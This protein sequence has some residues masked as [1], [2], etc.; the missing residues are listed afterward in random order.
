M[1]FFLCRDFTI[2]QASLLLA[3]CGF[4]LVS[5]FCHVSGKTRW[6]LCFLVAGSFCLFLFSSLLDPFLNL[7]DERFHA[8][9]A[10]NLMTH[11][12][13]PMLYADPVV[14]IP[15]DRWDR[16]YI[17]LNKQPFF[18]WPAAFFFHIFGV[19]EFALR[20]P[21]ALAGSILVLLAVRTGRLLVSDKTGYY[22][23]FLFATAFYMM[24]IISG[25]Q[26]LEHND[27]AFL[28]WVSASIWA[29]V[30]YVRS[31]K[32]RWMIF[33]AV[34][35]GVAI[36]VKWLVGLLV[37]LGW[38]VYIAF[39]RDRRKQEMVRLLLALSITF[40]VAVPWYGYILFNYPVEAAM[41][42][43]LYTAHLTMPLDGH[44]GN[45]WFHITNLPLLYGTL[46]TYLLIPAL[47]VLYQ[48][49]TP[50]PVTISLI[51]MLIATYLFF[52]IAQTKMPSLPWVASLPVYISIGTLMDAV[53]AWFHRI[54]AP[55][56]VLFVSTFL[57]LAVIGYFNLGIPELAYKHT[58]DVKRNR[59]LGNLSH[60]KQIFLDLPEQLPD[61]SVV[62]NVK[63][64]H[65]IECMFYS[66]FTSYPFI[67]STS[68]INDLHHQG[69]PV[70]I[71][72]SSRDTLPES[73]WNNQG[74]FIIH[75]TLQGWD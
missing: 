58:K 27:M 75:K 49:V 56:I 32:R 29:W 1:E 52:S 40:A 35:S 25:R 6:S 43:Q 13:K 70:A 37:Y 69:R 30:E 45:F 44:D 22:A 26:E 71:F 14:D 8:L 60:N 21:S 50:K 11:P 46:V 42:L 23:G 7:W 36:L 28:L 48:K 73:T 59:L 3:G 17:W 55:R 62:F 68:Q 51:T 67:P 57:S 47:L 12:F 41:T 19:N 33:L 9:V 39:T 18:L 64:R 61:H 66:G 54:K 5:L 10:K 16:A 74:V 15:Y 53:I 65:Y 72:Q 34:F 20:L 38:G 2:S 31:R 4:I 24:E 63:G